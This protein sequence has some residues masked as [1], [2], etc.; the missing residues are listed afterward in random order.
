MT[1]TGVDL[2]DDG[3]TSSSVVVSCT[4]VVLTT[5]VVGTGVELVV[6]GST[7]SVAVTGKLSTFS[8]AGGSGV[9]VARGVVTD[10]VVV[11][12]LQINSDGS[13]CAN[14]LRFRWS[15]L[16]QYWGFL[17]RLVTWRSLFAIHS[18]IQRT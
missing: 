2:L 5:L 1:A 13:I 16:P 8:V 9:G 3:D 10:G 11:V 12:T 15:G 4:G 17:S 6:V 18:A 7:I 14:V